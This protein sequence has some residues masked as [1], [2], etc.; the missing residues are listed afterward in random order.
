MTLIKSRL[1]DW[2]NEARQPA[3]LYAVAV[4]IPAEITLFLTDERVVV[5]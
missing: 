3:A 5:Y 4:L 1:R 2:P